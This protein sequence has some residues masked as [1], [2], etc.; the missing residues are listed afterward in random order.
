MRASLAAMSAATIASSAS[1]NA[2]NAF[3]GGRLDKDIRQ[4][5][6]FYGTAWKKE[7]T[8][9]H[10]LNALRSGFRGIDTATQPRHYYQPGVGDA[11]AEALR[12]GLIASRDELWLQTKFTSIS[13]QDPN[14]IP[15]NPKDPYP[16]QVTDSFAVAL[17]Q[18]G[19]DYVDS[20]VLHGPLPTFAK[21]MEVWA[22]MERLVDEKKVQLIGISNCY[23]ADYFERLYAEARIKPSILQ[24]RF[25]G[26]SGWDN[27][28]RHFC[29]QH[30]IIYQSFWTLTANPSILG[31]SSVIAAARR[32][33]STPEAV[34]Y[35]YLI[36][37]GARPLNGT[38]STAHMAEDLANIAKP[39]GAS[40]VAAISQLIRDTYQ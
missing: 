31:H 14:S 13:G 30:G 2:N 3:S 10:V 11:V 27:G 20:L 32:L 37:R 23:D 26:D 16:K 7:A 1:P 33:G 21:T 8:K 4:H 36:E 17:Q 12:S 39:L 34:L 19:T 29:R 18:L 28:L 40:E 38:T 6:S 35:R 9:G 15:Y 5:L 24:N 25:Y 22:A